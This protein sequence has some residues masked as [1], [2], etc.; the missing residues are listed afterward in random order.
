[1]H[2]VK[3]EPDQFSVADAAA[4]QELEDHAIPLRPRRGL[5]R[6]RS[7]DEV[8][9]LFDGWHTGQMFGQ[10]GCRDQSCRILFDVSSLGQPAKPRTNRGQRPG[11]RRLGQSPAQEFPEIGANRKML[12]LAHFDAAA[13]LLFKILDKAE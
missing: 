6:R 7:I 11:S 1:M 8:V 5:V 12:H 13:A 3:I 4:I 10:L 2:I 9:H